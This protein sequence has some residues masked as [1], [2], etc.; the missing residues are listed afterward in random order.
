[1]DEFVRK[2]TCEEREKR[3]EEWH[4]ML[5]SVALEWGFTVGENGKIDAQ[6]TE[7][8]VIKK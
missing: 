1:M 5:M 7:T 2:E 6:S 4:D 8:P 3:L